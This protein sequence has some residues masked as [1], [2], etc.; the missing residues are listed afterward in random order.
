MY[1]ITTI[2]NITTIIIVMCIYIYIYIYKLARASAATSPAA[3]IVGTTHEL[4]RGPA[5]CD[6]MVLGEGQM[7]VGTNWVAANFMLLTE[8]FFCVLPLT[9]FYLPKSARACLFPPK[10][11]KIA[12]FAA[13]PLLLTPFVRNQGPPSRGCSISSSPLASWRRACRRHGCIFRRG[14]L[15]MC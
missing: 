7:G 15:P 6:G 8:G 5:A 4:A 14:F 13:A 3:R 12:T 2:I 9:Y 1:I 10:L 11:S